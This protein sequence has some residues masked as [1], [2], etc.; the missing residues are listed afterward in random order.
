MLKIY[1]QLKT[2]VFTEDW[3][4]FKEGILVYHFSIITKSKSIPELEGFIR[5][6]K[7]VP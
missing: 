6:W 7:S 2:M 4:I 3:L 1:Q 5:E